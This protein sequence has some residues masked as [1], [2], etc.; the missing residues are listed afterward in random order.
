MKYP[1]SF[2]LA[3]IAWEIIC[4]ALA[5]PPIR[6]N[7]YFTLK[8]MF[9]LMGGKIRSVQHVFNIIRFFISGIIDKPNNVD[10]LELH[11]CVGKPPIRINLNLPLKTTDM[12][13]Y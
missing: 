7:L 6:I 3:P 12:D 11:C 9:K 5:S 1:L 13:N 2:D 8:S 4:V 10:W